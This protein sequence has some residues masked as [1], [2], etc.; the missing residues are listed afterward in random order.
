MTAR[1]IAPENTA[2]D[3]GEPVYPSRAM[4]AARHATPILAKNACDAVTSQAFCHGISVWMP[5]K[6][7]P[8]KVG[9][10]GC[11]V[12]SIL[13]SKILAQVLVLYGVGVRVPMPA[14]KIRPSA[15]GRWSYFCQAASIRIFR[16]IR[17]HYQVTY[18]YFLTIMGFSSPDFHLAC[19]HTFL[20]AGVI[21][22]GQ[23]TWVFY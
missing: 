18:I 11:A 4:P 17:F 23:S 12:T 8:H 15:K 6:P 2:G 16:F 13:R 20:V 3:S 1:R 22:S 19:E 10:R 5:T 9:R 7:G 14:P 21:S